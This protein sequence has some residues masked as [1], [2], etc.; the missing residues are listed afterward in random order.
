MKDFNLTSASQQVSHNS[1]L[2]L[3]MKVIMSVHR[4]EIAP[5]MNHLTREADSITVKL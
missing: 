5:E 3:Q 1:P 2:D 4:I